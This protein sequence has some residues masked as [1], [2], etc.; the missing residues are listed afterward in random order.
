MM[1]PEERRKKIGAVIRVASGNFLEQY[2]FFVYG[3]YAAYIGK[4]FFPNDSA[5]AS[6]M[7]SLA[8]FG[9]RLSHAP[10]RRGGA[11]GVHRPRGPARRPHRDPGPDGGRNAEHCGDPGLR[12]H[13]R[14]RAHHHRRRP[15]A[16]GLLGGCGA[17]R[18]FRLPLGDRHPRSSR[19]LLRLAIEQPADRGDHRGAARRGARRDP[20]AGADGQ[21][22]LAHSPAGGLRHHSPDPLAARIAGGDGGPFRR[23]VKRRTGSAT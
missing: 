22:R 4:V 3:Y 15:L 20:H 18:G 8:T 12:D 14:G 5:I 2:D 9:R 1:T 21:L 13:R 16:P 11:R 23:S 17:G 10:A 7:L 19:L 6:L